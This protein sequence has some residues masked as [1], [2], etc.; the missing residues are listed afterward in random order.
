MEVWV[1]P[2]KTG[3]GKMKQKFHLI[4]Y[5]CHKQALKKN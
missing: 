2:I 4:L 3:N 1:N 5:E